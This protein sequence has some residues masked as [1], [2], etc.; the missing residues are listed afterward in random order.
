MSLPK[1]HHYLPQFYL[2][3]FCRGNV[4]WIFD[5]ETGE[6]RSQTPIYTTVQTHFYSIRYEDGSKDHRLEQLLSQVESSVAPVITKA[7]NEGILSPDEKQIMSL[8]A[9]L[10][11]SRVP[12]YEKQHDELRRGILERLGDDVAPATEQEIADAPSVIPAEEAGPRI[13]AYD[14]VQNLKEI[15]NNPDLSHND[16]LRMILPM[17][18]NASE[19]LLQMSWIIV[20]APSDTAFITTDC[21]FQTLSPIGFDRSG[22]EGYG[23]ATPGAVKIMPL[24]NKSCLFIYDHGTRFG[25]VDIIRKHVRDINVTLAISCDRYL[26]SADEDRAKHIVKRSGIDK[27]KKGP[28]VIV[29]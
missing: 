2:R 23:I 29:Q 24:S 1:R 14:L 5:R 11:I 25:Y 28:R 6:Y 3:G 17:A 12:D 18:K 20:H 22:L 19:V 4:F 7:D 16:F 10:Q 15:E 27:G 21:P 26:I 8:F 13:S 9:G